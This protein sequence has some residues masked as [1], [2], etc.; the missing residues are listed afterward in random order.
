MSEPTADDIR[1]LT[2]ALLSVDDTL[3]KILDELVSYGL[4]NAIKSIRESLSERSL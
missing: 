2:Q 1:D 3:T 4:A